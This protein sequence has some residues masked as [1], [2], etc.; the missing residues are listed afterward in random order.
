MLDS[1]TVTNNESVK[2]IINFNPQMPHFGFD[3]RNNNS[4]ASRKD[5]ETYGWLFGGR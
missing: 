4:G 5:Y 3:N 2:E 1:W